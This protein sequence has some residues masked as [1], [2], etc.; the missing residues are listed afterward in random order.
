MASARKRGNTYQIR[1]SCGFRQDGTRIIETKNWTPP[2]DLSLAM[3]K[4]ELKKQC[5]LFEEKVKST[6]FVSI[7]HTFASF[8]QL[9]IDKYASV[10]LAPKTVHRYKEL[11]SRINTSIGHIKIEKLLP[12]HFVDLYQRLRNGEEKKNKTYAIRSQDIAQNALIGITRT[13]LSMKSKIAPNTLRNVLSGKNV[14][15]YV[16]L[17]VSKALQRPFDDL[18]QR[19]GLEKM[20]LSDRSILAHHRLIS[21]IL[22]DAVEWQMITDNPLKRV[23]APR[24]RKSDI[25]YL[26]NEQAIELICKLDDC[27]IQHRTMILMLLF[28]GFRRSELC[29]LKWRDIDYFNNLITVRRSIQYLPEKGLFEKTPKNDT[30]CRAISFSTDITDLLK[31]YLKFQAKQKV[32][33]GDLWQNTDYVFTTWNGSP[34]NPDSLTSWFAKFIEKSGLPRITIHGLRHT[35]ATLMIG[36]GVDIR[37]VANRL[38]H[39]QASTTTNIYAHAI[40]SVDRQAAERL[41][42]ILRRDKAK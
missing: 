42:T 2:I 38:G 9:W 39:S 35:N 26:N 23:K 27:D 13:Q 32:D 25:T 29:G 28:L 16:A 24:A 31:E 41:H 8:S 17:S 15:E 20:R 12:S 18:F 34:I 7:H 19:S 1:V 3:I 14:N 36:S 22:N 10:E 6:Q 37:T 4:K 11:L 21:A 40:N 33:A 30:S 5:V